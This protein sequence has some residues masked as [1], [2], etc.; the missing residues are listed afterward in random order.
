[1]ND[2]ALPAE[3][4]TLL[5]RLGVAL[6][7]GLL[8]GLQRER[9]Q[10]QE[11]LGGV[12][13][14][15]LIALTGGALTATAPVAGPWPAAAGLLALTAVIVM[16]N[17]AALRRGALE[18][19]VTT[20]VAALAVYAVGALTV[21]GPLPAA[22]ALGG[23]VAVL[24]HAKAPLHAFVRRLGEQ[25]VRAIMR[26]ALITLVILPALPD[27]AVGPYSVLNP[28]Q[29]WMMVVL[30]VAVS[31]L[32]YVA[33]RLFSARTGALLNGVLGGL[34]SS[35]ATT[36][37]CARRARRA[38][39]AA[40]LLVMLLAAAVMDARVYILAGAVS[41]AL[42][43]R[44]APPLAMMLAAALLPATAISLQLRAARADASHNNFIPDNP[45]E[46]RPALLFAAIY[47]LVL[48]ASA[49][50]KDLLGGSGFYLVA[51]LSGLTDMDAITLTAARLVSQEAL[52]LET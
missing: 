45:A 18:P 30:V 10:G 29:I 51:A 35:T 28:R 6:G 9:Q 33:H 36:I 21:A 32:G 39:I 4:A 42:A 3:S 41:P 13:T 5:L 48:L 27:R 24:L 22:V 31:L 1:M 44:L 19:G 26:F 43:Q 52:A 8:V 16:S 7:L 12:R 49:W 11:R 2:A 23:V 47:A 17:V 15:P 37:A 38:G 34:V 50:A 40:A 20:E 14:F 46:L 25:D